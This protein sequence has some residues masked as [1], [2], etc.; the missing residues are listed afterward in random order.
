[1]IIYDENVEKVMNFEY[2]NFKKRYI[3]DDDFDFKVPNVKFQ[4]NVFKRLSVEITGTRYCEVCGK[5]FKPKI[6]SNGLISD[7]T[8]CSKKCSK[9]RTK[10]RNLK[11][12]GY[13]SH[14]QS[15][16][17]KAKQ[18]KACLEKYGTKNAGSRPEA[19][20]KAHKTC[21]EKYGVENGS[22]S[23]EARKKNISSCNKTCFYNR[24]E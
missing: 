13:E 6:L 21:L 10:I 5:E 16:E 7:E 1:M 20:E 11:K 19:I 12:Y 3:K 8:I 18:Q 2:Q 17:I 24:N 9:E 23:K 15:P 14:N 4:G 22:Q